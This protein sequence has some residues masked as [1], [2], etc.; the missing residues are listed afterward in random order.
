[1]SRNTSSIR[2][3][4]RHAGG[5]IYIYHALRFIDPSDGKRK[6]RYYKSH[7]EAYDAQLSLGLAI[8]EGR[9]NARSADITG[10]PPM[11]FH[12]LRHVA[13]TA[14][15]SAGLP[16]GAVHRHLGHASFATTLKLYGSL[17]DAVRVEAA[18]AIAAAFEPKPSKPATNGSG[19]P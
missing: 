4:T 7:R 15:V 5:H 2:K 9:Y 17:T 11:P 3:V 6:I 19:Q 10:L 1:M 18:D 12:V 14:L 16:P 8:K 13:A